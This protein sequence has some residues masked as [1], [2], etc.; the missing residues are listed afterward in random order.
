R[1]VL[2]GQ[3]CT[4]LRMVGDLIIALA[5]RGLDL[6]E[7]VFDHAAGERRLGEP[8]LEAASLFG[9]RRQGAPGF[10]EQLLG[11]ARA[12]LQRIEAHALGVELVLEAL[13]GVVE[14]GRE[15]GA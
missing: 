5:E 10:V 11:G 1:S 13:A 7:L 14:R 6:S 9:A 8:P 4:R 3:R 2:L 15:A 12:G